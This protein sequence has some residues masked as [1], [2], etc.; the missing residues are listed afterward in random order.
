MD[1]G[2]CLGKGVHPVRPLKWTLDL[3]CY[4]NIGGILAL[5]RNYTVGIS[6]S[7]LRRSKLGPRRVSIALTTARPV[8]GSELAAYANASKREVLVV[9]LRRRFGS[10]R[11]QRAKQPEISGGSDDLLEDDTK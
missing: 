9:L 7:S 4:D 6:R 3:I 11:N 1:S 8:G 2:R 10:Q 5:H